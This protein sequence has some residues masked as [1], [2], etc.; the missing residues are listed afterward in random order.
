[1]SFSGNG[2][3]TNPLKA[4]TILVT[5]GRDTKA[6]K[7]FVNPPVVHGSTV[8]YPTAADLHAHRGE[9]QYGRR[10]TPTTKALQEALMALE[11]PQCAG[12][13][14]RALGPGRDH[15]HPARGAEV[16]RS[17]AGLRQCLSSHPQFL[18]RHPGPLRRRDQLFRSADRRRHRRPVQAQYQGGGGR[19][20]GLAILRN[21]RH[22]RDRSGRACARRARD[23]R[24]HLG[25]GAVSSLAGARRRYQH[26]GGDQIYRRPFR[27]HVRHHCGQCQGLAAGGRGDPVCSASAPAPTTCSWRCAGCARF[28]CGW[29]SITSPASRWRTGW[30]AGRRSSGCCTL[31]SKT[32]PAMRSGSGILPARPACS[33]SCCSRS[34]K[35]PSM[36]CSIPSSCSAWAI[37]G[38]A[39]KASSFPF[40]CAPYRTATQWAPGGPALRLHI[41]LENVEDLKADLDRGFAAFNA[42]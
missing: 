10:G 12:V 29:R 15:H 9:F 13:G 41:G 21:A 30:P 5:A 25:D 34:R 37:H 27:H 38:A 33:A 32:I 40:D 11:G 7:G 2:G 28:R 6:Q 14:D 19:G 39:S 31:P 35:P 3:P 17:P 16:R 36:P 22:S 1:M 20:A 8:L 26:A 4:E 23:R 18:Q 24:Q 42:A